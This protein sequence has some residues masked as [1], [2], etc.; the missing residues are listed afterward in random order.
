MKSYE[1]IVKDRETGLAI[2]KENIVNNNDF[3]NK[4]ETKKEKKAFNNEIITVDEEKAISSYNINDNYTT[5][6]LAF[7]NLYIEGEMLNTSKFSSINSAFKLQP[8]SD[9]NIKNINIK[10]S[11]DKYKTE[12][13]R[14]SSTNN[15]SKNKYDT[16]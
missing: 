1:K 3:N 10:E 5:L 4:F 2:P 12:T 11:I 9:R 8:I 6:D 13:T 15:F 16:W 7:N 14:L